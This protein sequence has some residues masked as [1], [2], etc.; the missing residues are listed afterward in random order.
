MFTYL[1]ICFYQVYQD[2]H[3]KYVDLLD[4]IWRP[5]QVE[6]RRME[7]GGRYGGGGGGGEGGRDRGK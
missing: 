3:S 6:G 5:H 7:R 4:L 2:R 1:C